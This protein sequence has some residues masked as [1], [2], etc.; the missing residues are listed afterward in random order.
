M[1]VGLVVWFGSSFLVP[2]LP[3][4]LIG[5]LACLAALLIVTPLTQQ[6]DP[7]RAVQNQHGEEVEL[8]DRLGTLPLFRRIPD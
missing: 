7:P 3:G 6:S 1:A 8:G 4:D 5:M 2:S